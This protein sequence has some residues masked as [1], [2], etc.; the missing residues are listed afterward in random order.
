DT[1]SSFRNN[2]FGKSV[3]NQVRMQS[4]VMAEKYLRSSRDIKCTQK[5]F[6]NVAHIPIPSTMTRPHSAQS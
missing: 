4:A 5:T 3:M 1:G 2:N 6:C